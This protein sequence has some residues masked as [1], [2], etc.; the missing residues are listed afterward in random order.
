MTAAK[1]WIGG[2]TV[3]CSMIEVSRIVA[4]AHFLGPRVTRERHLEPVGPSTK[5]TANACC[6][7]DRHHARQS[8]RETQQPLRACHTRLIKGVRDAR[9]L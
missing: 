4:R 1:I 3:R 2:P 9:D 6:G 8:G 7:R 5:P